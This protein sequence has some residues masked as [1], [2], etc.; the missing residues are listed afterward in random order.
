MIVMGYTKEVAMRHGLLLPCF[1]CE[2]CGD[3]T[4]MPGLCRVCQV[5]SD[6]AWFLEEARRDREESDEN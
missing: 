1:K 5:A 2:S 4:T 6:E 3:T